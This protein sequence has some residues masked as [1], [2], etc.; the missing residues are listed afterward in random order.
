MCNIEAGKGNIQ[1]EQPTQPGRGEQDGKSTQPSLGGFQ[2][3]LDTKELDRD[4][5]TQP[6]RGRDLGGYSEQK[7]QPE[8]KNKKKK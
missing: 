7:E 4:R 5:R 1:K 8:R 3:M 6:E 2:R